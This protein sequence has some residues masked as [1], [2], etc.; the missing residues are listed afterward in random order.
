MNIL[1]VYS[2][3]VYKILC[4]FHEHLNILRTFLYCSVHLESTEHER[5]ILGIF[6]VSWALTLS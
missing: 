3:K 6:R 1:L 4:T 5:N 2:R